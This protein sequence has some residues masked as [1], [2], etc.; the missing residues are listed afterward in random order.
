VLQFN[1][2]R[3]TLLTFISIPL[4]FVGIPYGLL[5][6]GQ[7]L[8][9]FGTLGIISLAGII[10]NNAIVLIDQIDIERA[11][12]DLRDAIVA[13]SEKR[14]RPILLTSATTVLGLAPMAIAGGALWQPMAVL[15]MSGLAVAS[16]LTLFFVPAGYFLLFRFDKAIAFPHGKSK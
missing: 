12:L 4:I 3:R 5:L 13:A 1:S 6:T 16:L 10:I 8:S 9:F 15:M 11:N 14:L 7:P 2:F